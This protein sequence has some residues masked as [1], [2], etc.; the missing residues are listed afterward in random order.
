[1]WWR[2]ISL[3]L[4][5]SA[6][7]LVCNAQNAPEDPMVPG[8]ELS[9]QMPCAPTIVANQMYLSQERELIYEGKTAKEDLTLQFW[10]GPHYDWYILLVVPSQEVSC[11]LLSGGDLKIKSTL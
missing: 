4:T 5:L 8:I 2:K 11:L 6:A 7:P 3:A 1:M 9:L 10:R